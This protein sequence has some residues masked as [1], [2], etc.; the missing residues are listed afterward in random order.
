MSARQGVV[1]VVIQKGSSISLRLLE[2]MILLAGTLA[3]VYPA[4]WA[5]YLWGGFAEPRV[6]IWGFVQ[7]ELISTAFLSVIAI[8]AAQLARRRTFQT[9]VLY[10]LALA[11]VL[12]AIVIPMG[13][14]DGGLERALRQTAVQFLPISLISGAFGA[15]SL[16]L[17]EKVLPLS[18]VGLRD[19]SVRDKED[20]MRRLGTNPAGE[21]AHKALTLGQGEDSCS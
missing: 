19:P 20:S 3:G 21:D 13:V 8:G 12:V 1:S 4:M 18:S 14:F 16:V 6:F 17:A 9:A 15:L 7:A 10:M 5:V 2:S 11:V